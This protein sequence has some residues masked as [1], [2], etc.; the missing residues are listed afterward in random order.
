MHGCLLLLMIVALWPR[1]TLAAD[2][3][4]AVLDDGYFG[5]DTRELSITDAQAAV[6]QFAKLAAHEA[7]ILDRCGLHSVNPRLAA[8]LLDASGALEAP[9]GDGN[10]AMRARIDAFLTAL[11]HMFYLGRTR[12]AVPAQRFNVPRE[13]TASATPE[14]AGLNA[15]ADTF[16]TGDE[17]AGTL[18][19]IYLQRFGVRTPV[20]SV[21]AQAK[22]GEITTEANPSNWM[23]LPWLLGQQGWSF[24]G[25]HSSS[26]G[27]PN[28]VC[29]QPRSSIDFSNGW[30]VW[31]SNTTRSPVLAANDGVVTVFSSCNVRIT[32]ANGWASSYYHLSNIRVTNGSSVVVGQNIA[33]F[34]DT[35]AQAL[36]QGGSSTGPH[37]HFTLINAGVQVDIDQSDFSGWRVN[38]TAV[39]RDYDSDCSRMNVTRAG[40][41]ACPYVGNSPVAWGMHSLAAGMASNKLCDL[42]VDGNGTVSAATDGVLLLRYLIGLRGPALIANAIGAGAARSTY[43]AVESFMASRRYDLDGD[44]T[45]VTAVDGLLALRLMRGATGTALSGGAIN[46]SSIVT[47]GAQIDAL[48]AGCR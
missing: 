25:A 40:S 42:D 28:P 22:A 18:A 38:A 27:C 23:R 44:N 37:V 29:A 36:C 13:S 9:G 17:R 39:I 45:T 8:L 30:P 16:L 14:S 4:T 35:Q 19:R 7:L 20:A 46:A 3:P 33:D 10:E 12:A 1:S 41:T 11:P 43:P 24:N 2:S 6:R 48:A 34:A 47:T 31:G 15:L 26:G 32:H 21:A 5:W